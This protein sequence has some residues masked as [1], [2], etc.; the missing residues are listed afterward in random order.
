VT[1]IKEFN[2]SS[3]T[4]GRRPFLV[5]SGLSLGALLTLPSLAAGAAGSKVAIPLAKLE[6]LKSVGG[7]I[8]IKVKDKLLLLVRD[9][10]TSVRAFN[11]VCTHRQCVVAFNAG[12][13]KIKCPC[14]GSQFDLDGR[15]IHGPA[16][17]PLEA[18]PAE[19]VN[20]QVIVT[21]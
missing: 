19:L 4:F 10:A 7:S 8:A 21:L 2:M 6:T 20:E 18:Y 14:H 1:S 9:S 11:P 5:G 13:K 3:S 15:V 12:D 16:S 17:R